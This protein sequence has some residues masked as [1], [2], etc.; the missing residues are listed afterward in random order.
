MKETVLWLIQRISGAILFMGLGLHIYVMHFMGTEQLSYELIIAR[1]NNPLWII[2]NITFLISAVYHGFNGLWG[3]ALEC[4]SNKTAQ[5]IAG[6]AICA[7]SIT[8]SG[9]GIYILTLG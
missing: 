2:F 8:L 7:T 3:I 1:L 4:I 6:Y 5:R 9:V